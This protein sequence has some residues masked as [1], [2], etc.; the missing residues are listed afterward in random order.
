MTIGKLRTAMRILLLL[1]RE[2]MPEIRVRAPANPK[3]V[4]TR[5]M[6]KRG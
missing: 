6:R 5:V 2:A 3:E 1:A 4:S